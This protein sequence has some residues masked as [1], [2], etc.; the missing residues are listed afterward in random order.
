MAKPPAGSS[1]LFNRGPLFQEPPSPPPDEGSTPPP[2]NGGSTTPVNAQPP[3]GSSL[4][5][6]ALA[7]SGRIKELKSGKYPGSYRMVLEGV[8]EIDRFTDRPDTVKGSWKPQ[9][10]V[11]KWDKLFATSTPNAQA[12]VEAD[13]QRELFTFQMFKPKKIRSGKMMFNIKPL[14]ESSEDKVTSFAGKGL[15]KLSLSIDYDRLLASNGADTFYFKPSRQKSDTNKKPVIISDFDHSEKDT[16]SIDHKSY[17]NSQKDITLFKTKSADIS[18]LSTN[19]ADV[20]YNKNTG[21]MHFNA[22]GAKPGLGRQGGLLAILEG[23]PNLKPSSINF[24]EPGGTD[25]P[26]L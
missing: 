9:R 12:T 2:L 22:N 4:L 19:I 23:A 11:R 25:N 20:I 17:S 13:G 24:Y 14:S 8:D 7:D 16:I 15:D 5:F 1:L 3:A 18:K 21:E 26:M 6:G 10:L